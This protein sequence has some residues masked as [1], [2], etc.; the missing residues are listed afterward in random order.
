MPVAWAGQKG[1]GVSAELGLSVGLAVSR[2]M[3]EVFLDEL[4]NH[5]EVARN[6]PGQN[7]GVES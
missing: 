6:L 3:V 2:E 7:A 4:D 1:F 5:P